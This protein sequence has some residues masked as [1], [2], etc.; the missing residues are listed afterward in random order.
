MLATAPPP[1]GTDLY[2]RILAAPSGLVLLESVD[3]QVLLGQFRG[4]ARYTGQAIYLWQPD[5]GLANLLDPQVRVPGSQRLGAA[6]RY[7]QESMHFGV[8][9]L[10]GIELPLS[11]MDSTLLRQLAKPSNGP[12]RRVV[13]IEPSPALVE[14]FIDAGVRMQ[15]RTQTPRHPRLRD[16]RW[17][18]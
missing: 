10:I 4:V 2:E 11:A 7:M 13:L 3:S 8:Y 12:V 6:L 9:L 14:H 16:G 17:I 1:A 15:G 5:Q 18:T